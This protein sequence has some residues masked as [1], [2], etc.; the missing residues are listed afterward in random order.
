MTLV[1]IIVWLVFGAIIGWLAKLLYP[2]DEAI[3]G[4][5]TVLLGITG[6]FVGGFINWAVGWSAGGPVSASGF[7]MSLLGAIACCWLYTN[8]DKLK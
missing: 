5:G 6:S 1:G 3:S 7:G 2:G 8:R 4:W